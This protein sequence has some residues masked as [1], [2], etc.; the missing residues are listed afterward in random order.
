MEEDKKSE[1]L[2]IGP[3]VLSP[4][5]EKKKTAFFFALAQS[6]LPANIEVNPPGDFQ[7]DI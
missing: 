2:G 7:G 1:I 5:E 4:E 3:V 6:G